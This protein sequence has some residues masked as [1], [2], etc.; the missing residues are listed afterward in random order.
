MGER[1]RTHEGS[2]ERIGQ[3]ERHCRVLGEAV[4]SSQLL[5][6]VGAHHPCDEHPARDA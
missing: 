3:L 2:A 1:E 4:E 5:E 6:H